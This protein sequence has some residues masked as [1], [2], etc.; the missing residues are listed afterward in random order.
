MQFSGLGSSK[1]EFSETDFFHTLTIQNDQISYVKHVLDP[2][3]V[4]FT[5]FGCVWGGGG[6]TKGSRAHNLLMQFPAS[7]AQKWKFSETDFFDTLTIQNDQISYVK[8]GVAVLP[9]ASESPLV[10][11]CELWVFAMCPA[12]RGSTVSYAGVAHFPKHSLEYSLNFWSQSKKKKSYVKH[13]L[14][15]VHVSFT[16]FG[17]GGGGGGVPRGLGHTACLCS[18]QTSAAQKWKFPKLIFLIL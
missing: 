17:C 11:A 7:A 13:V 18:F 3:H 2:V 12:L 10:Y 8:H 14:D 16:L 1:M 6:G 5:Q 4:F 15:P 9:T